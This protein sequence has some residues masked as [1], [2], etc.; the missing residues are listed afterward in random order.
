MLCPSAQVA[1]GSPTRLAGMLSCSPSWP[2]TTSFAADHCPNLGERGTP[3]RM[4]MSRRPDSPIYPSCRHP[5]GQCAGL[6]YPDVSDKPIEGRHLDYHWNGARVDLYRET[7][8]GKVY[9]V[10]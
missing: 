4:K 7:G 3:V 1:E 10:D 6:F 9:R 2:E 8:T 5:G